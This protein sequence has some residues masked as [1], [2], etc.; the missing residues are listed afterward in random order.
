MPDFISTPPKPKKKIPVVTL[1]GLIDGLIEYLPTAFD[2]VYHRSGIWPEREYGLAKTTIYFYDA[3]RTV[4][5]IKSAIDVEIDGKFAQS[6]SARL[7]SDP[8]LLTLWQRPEV[9]PP[10]PPLT[11]G[12]K[13]EDYQAYIRTLGTMSG[14]FVVP[15]PDRSML[16]RPVTRWDRGKPMFDE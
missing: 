6:G 2:F 3:R 5:P 10:R 11:A 13:L 7:Y 16:F 1:D 15:Q 9:E 8:F 14:L 4:P 12:A